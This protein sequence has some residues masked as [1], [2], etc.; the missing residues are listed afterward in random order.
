M[1]PKSQSPS[2]L[3]QCTHCNYIYTHPLATTSSTA[4]RRRS[5]PPLS[6]SR[7]SRSQPRRAPSVD[8]GHDGGVRVGIR[9]PARLLIVVDS[10]VVR[11]RPEHDGEAI[12]LVGEPHPYRRRGVVLFQQLHEFRRQVGQSSGGAILMVRHRD[13]GGN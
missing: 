10:D 12:G 8:A 1:F 13:C 9:R 4:V 7:I 6:R 2:Q 5:Q 3:H 11:R